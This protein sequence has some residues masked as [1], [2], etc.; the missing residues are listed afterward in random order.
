[1]FCRV[2]LES[3]R[4]SRLPTF[5]YR[6][7]STAPAKL[8]VSRRAM[9]Y[10]P[11]SNP[12]MLEKSLSSP[13]DSVA[14]DLEDSVSPGKK[15]DAR[16]LVAE[17]LDGERRPKGEVVARINAIGTGY[18]NDD[19]DHVLRT[20]H[21]QAIALPKTNSPEHIEYV[22]SRINALAPPHKRS[23]QPEAIKIIAMIEN[24][25][26]MVAIEAIAASGNGHLDALLSDCADV[27]LTRT[28]SRQ[29]LLYPRSRLVTTAKAFG[30]QAIDLVCVNYKDK[31]VLREES[32]EGRR[33][34]FDGKQ[35]IHPEQIDIIHS[36]FA[37]S[38]KDILKAARVKFSFE[39]YDQLGKGAYTL[40][41]VM[42]DAP[43]YKQATKVLAKA[44][45]A[46]LEIP[47]VRLS[48]I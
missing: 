28:L 44:G 43:V 42:I 36:S 1:M 31:E 39:H 45:A 23:G 26:A 17:L 12:R 29:E 8:P 5:L 40:D 25:Q 6:P 18:E 34:G 14:Y 38:E 9:L 11:G 21:V 37:P 32:E 30:L 48:D 19:L 15:A 16:R 47:K 2:S 3:T 10:V 24:A 35:A 33:L 46:G 4:L 7:I 27:G 22:I 20:R 41:G 13:A